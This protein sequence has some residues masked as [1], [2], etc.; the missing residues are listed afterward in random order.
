MKTRKEIRTQIKKDQNATNEYLRFD[1]DTVALIDRIENEP[2]FRE[3]AIRAVSVH[4]EMLNLLKGF[5]ENLDLNDRHD[6]AQ[7]SALVY[8]AISK[9]EGK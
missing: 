7:F 4:D 3:F 8:K 5:V 1:L 2:A 6:V 9:A